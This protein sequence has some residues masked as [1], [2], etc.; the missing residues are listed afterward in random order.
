MMRPPELPAALHGEQTG[1]RAGDGAAWRARPPLAASPRTPYPAWGR[2]T[3]N[4]TID[5]NCKRS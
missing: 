5:H 1:V 2:K 3:G 4:S